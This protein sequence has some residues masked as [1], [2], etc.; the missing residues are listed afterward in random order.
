MRIDVGEVD[1]W[2]AEEGR[3]VGRERPEDDAGAELRGNPAIAGAMVVEIFVAERDLG[4]IVR[5]ERDLRVD[6]VAL[7][8]HEFPI[9]VGIL[10]HGVNSAGQVWA[11]GLP[12]IAWR[13]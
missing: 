11:D 13:D 7:D 6:A 5:A 1:G 12:D 8:V 3:R 2:I 4:A 9:A 10:V